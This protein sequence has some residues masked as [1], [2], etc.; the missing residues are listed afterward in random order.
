MEL[1]ERLH[2]PESYV[3][4]FAAFL[5]HMLDYDN[6]NRVICQRTELSFVMAGQRVHAKPNVCLM[7][8]VEL[9]LI[10]ENK[11]SQ[12]NPSTGLT[13]LLSACFVE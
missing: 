10:Q 8:T 4:D 6:D 7:G 1:V 12:T 3:D 2:S 11:V 5:M 13:K 9:L